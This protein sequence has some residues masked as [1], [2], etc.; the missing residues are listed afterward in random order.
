M[1]EA[2]CVWEVVVVPVAPVAD[3]VALAASEEDVLQ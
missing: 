2:E 1:E 3:L